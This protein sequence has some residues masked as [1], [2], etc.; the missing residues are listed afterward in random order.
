MGETDLRQQ[1][2]PLRM[3]AYYFSFRP[4]GEVAI[5]R[6]LS[7]VATAGKHFHHTQEWGESRTFTD[8]ETEESCIQ[9]AANEAAQALAAARQET[10]QQIAEKIEK[11]KWG[12]LD[13]TYDFAARDRNAIVDEC[14]ALA[15]ET[16][17]KGTDDDQ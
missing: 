17:T 10:A 6:I 12:L 3:D 8:G 1:P 4:T 7:A 9:R 5:D 11:A 14:A 2:E 13:P 16:A 15:R